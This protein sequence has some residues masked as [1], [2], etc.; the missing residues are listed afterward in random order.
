MSRL[1]VSFVIPHSSLVSKVPPPLLSLL[2]HR[3]HR[4]VEHLLF[5]FSSGRERT[6]VFD[7]QEEERGAEGADPETENNRKPR[8]FPEVTSFVKLF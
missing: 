5:F 2:P 4:F 1:F 8:E 7:G 3:I 6:G